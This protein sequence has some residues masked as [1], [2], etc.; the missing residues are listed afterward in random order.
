MEAAG[1]DLVVLADVSFRMWCLSQSRPVRMMYFLALKEKVLEY[2]PESK[3]LLEGYRAGEYYGLRSV[4]VNTGPMGAVE[5][6]GETTALF[7]R[8]TRRCWAR[9][10]WTL[11]RVYSFAVFCRG[12]FVGFGG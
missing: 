9:R 3:Y 1:A 2:V 5:G 10:W 11:G 6:S 8:L 7:A 4:D 12:V